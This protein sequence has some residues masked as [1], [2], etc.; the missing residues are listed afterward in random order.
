MNLHK[1]FER[2]IFTNDQVIRFSRY[3]YYPML[4]EIEKSEFCFF[5]VKTCSSVFTETEKLEYLEKFHI[6][7]F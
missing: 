2:K 4:K 5:Y 6:P 7:P 3:G 1:K